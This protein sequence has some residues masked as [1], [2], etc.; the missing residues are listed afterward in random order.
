VLLQ[1][2]IAIEPDD[3][4]TSLSYKSSVVGADMLVK[5]VQLV[6]AGNPPRISQDEQQ[7]SYYSIPTPADQR[8]FRQRGGKYGTIFELWQH[9]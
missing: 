6:E 3:T 7:A 1:E 5:A 8:R 2:K 9:M 4:I